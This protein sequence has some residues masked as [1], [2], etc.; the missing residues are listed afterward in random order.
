MDSWGTDL[1]KSDVVV[2]HKHAR[3][4]W[5][6]AHMKYTFF[7][8]ALEQVFKFFMKTINFEVVLEVTNFENY[9]F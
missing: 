1:E 8:T 9:Q 2:P 6:R 4:I 5:R 3:A 7:P